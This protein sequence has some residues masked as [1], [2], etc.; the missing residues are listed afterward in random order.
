MFWL[1]TGKTRGE[2]LAG[3]GGGP[4]VTGLSLGALDF[5]GGKLA[6]KHFG[7]SEFGVSEG[8][9]G[10]TRVTVGKRLSDRMEVRVVHE[11]GRDTNLALNVEDQVTDRLGGGAV[12]QSRGAVPA[13]LRARVAGGRRGAGGGRG[14]GAWGGGGCRQGGC[15]RGNCG[16]QGGGEAQPGGMQTTQGLVEGDRVGELGVIGEQG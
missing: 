5:I 8:E 7:L 2:A 15:G 13:A 9:S 14:R 12:P 3:G 10:G 4:G 16:G 11:I 1:A 6:K